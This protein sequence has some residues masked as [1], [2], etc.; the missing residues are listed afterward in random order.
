MNNVH[1]IQNV[2]CKSFN[3]IVHVFE[4]IVH[5]NT[6]KYTHAVENI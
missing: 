2:V 4:E 3:N 6:L 1:Y 5:I